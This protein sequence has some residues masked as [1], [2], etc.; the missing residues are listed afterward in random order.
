MPQILGN[1]EVTAIANATT[2][3]GAVIIYILYIFIEPMID[4]I[5][6][7]NGVEI[8][9]ILKVVYFT[10]TGLMQLVSHLTSLG[11]DSEEQEKIKSKAEEICNISSISGV[12]NKDTK[13]ITWKYENYLFLLMLVSLDNET[14][15]ERFCNIVMLEAKA[16]Y[17]QDNF[18]IEKTYTCI[19]GTVKGKFDP[20]LP[21]G[22]IATGGLFEQERSRMRG[23]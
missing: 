17:G 1:K 5:L 18:D 7:V 2:P 9:L 15:V 19:E 12:L 21:F 6:I 4:T 20:V 14:A 10:P 11:L 23:Y 22:S 3:I 13:G 8:S 16:Y